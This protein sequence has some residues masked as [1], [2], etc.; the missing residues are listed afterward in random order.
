[1]SN[2]QQSSSVKTCATCGGV[3]SDRYVTDSH[4]FEGDCIREFQGQIEALKSERRKIHMLIAG[5]DG[6]GEG[7]KVSDLAPF[8]EGF[9]REGNELR[10]ELAAKDRELDDLK[11]WQQKVC[12]IVQPAQ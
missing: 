10:T 3:R 5:T 6:E 1:M 8:V 7:T 2:Q 9:M 12:S 4:F 11:E